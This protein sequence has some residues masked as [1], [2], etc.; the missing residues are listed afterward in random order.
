M[1]HQVRKGREQ[2][3]ESV[4]IECRA[5]QELEGLSVPAETENLARE[6]MRGKITFSEA[7]ARVLLRHGIRIAA[8]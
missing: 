1:E 3:I 5:N 7:R 6:M 8:G 2:V 4:I